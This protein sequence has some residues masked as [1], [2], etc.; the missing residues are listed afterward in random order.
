MRLERYPLPSCFIHPGIPL[1]VLAQ[2]L[3]ITSEFHSKKDKDMRKIVVL[4]QIT[5]FVSFVYLTSSCIAKRE[6][7][8]EGN[9]PAVIRYGENGVPNFIKGNNLSA[10]L[11]NDKAYQILK[12]QKHYAQM[13][14]YY[15]DRQ[16]SLFKLTSAQ[17]EFVVDTIDSDVTGQTHVKLRQVFNNIPVWG[18]ALGVHLNSD[19]QIY[20]FHGSYQPISAGIATEAVIS[21]ATAG[22]IA[23][24][25]KKDSNQWR[26]DSSD[27]CIYAPANDVQ[28][29]SYRVNLIRNA[30]HRE[31]CFID[32]VGGRILYCVSRTT[33]PNTFIK[34]KL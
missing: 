7:V 5:F 14:F 21:E 24:Q 30:L 26:I 11:E 4:F 12:A 31:Y 1:T 25:S 32:A 8:D 15:L 29:L 10:P 3:H 28:H 18:M 17:Q 23:L 19:D 2:T 33:N 22:Q 13:V 20:Y 6:V 16:R 9:G 34:E 27:K